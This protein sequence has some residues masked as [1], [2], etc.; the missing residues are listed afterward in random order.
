MVTR[1]M[2]IFVEITVKEKNDAFQNRYMDQ[3]QQNCSCAAHIPLVKNKNG[4]STKR[5]Y[6][7]WCNG[8]GYTPSKEVRG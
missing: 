8:H 5:N 6:N 4:S 2:Q 7:C 1:H 3:P